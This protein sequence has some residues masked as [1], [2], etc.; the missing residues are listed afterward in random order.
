MQR[1]YL[2]GRAMGINAVMASPK[3]QEM[4]RA[5]ASSAAQAK[6]EA[7]QKKWFSPLIPPI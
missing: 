3:V 2:G 6:M 7:A 4:Q 1:F 5:A